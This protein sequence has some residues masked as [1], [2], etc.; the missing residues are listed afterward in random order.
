MLKVKIMKIYL[1][2][3]AVLYLI[4]ALLHVLDLFDQ[5]LIFSQMDS[6]RKAWIVYLTIGDSIAAVGLWRLKKYGEIT[7]LVVAVSQLIAYGIF[8]SVFG[9]QTPLI[10]F[11]VVT[12]L[13]Y[14]ILKMKTRGET[15]LIDKAV[16]RV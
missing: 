14:G 13:L 16:K 2:I 12:V 3:L 1:R 7:F 6:L 15:G 9:D 11:H 8:K 10:I 4:G 5:R